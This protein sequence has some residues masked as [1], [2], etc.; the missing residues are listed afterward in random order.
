MNDIF[1]IDNSVV[2]SLLKQP[3][4]SISKFCQYNNKIVG[5]RQDIA[6]LCRILITLIKLK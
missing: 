5:S 6:V 1:V 3:E 2:K 4:I